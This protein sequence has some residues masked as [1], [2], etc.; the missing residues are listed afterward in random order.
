M[1]SFQ[2][3][4][5]SISSTKDNDEN[6]PKDDNGGFRP[7]TSILSSAAS[8]MEDYNRLLYAVLNDESEGERPNSS[9]SS[10]PTASENPEGQGRRDS[11]RASEPSALEV[12][13]QAERR[14]SKHISNKATELDTVV[15]E[16][17]LEIKALKE[18]LA[19]ATG[20][21]Q[22]P[23]ESP[24]AHF[25]RP[26]R[27]KDAD[28][29]EMRERLAGV[30]NWGRRDNSSPPE[31][32]KR[33]SISM[34][35]RGSVKNENARRQSVTSGKPQRAFLHST[36]PTRQS[37]FSPLLDDSGQIDRQ[38]ELRVGGEGDSGVHRRGPPQR[39]RGHQRWQPGSTQISGQS[40]L[41]PWDAGYRCCAFFLSLSLSVSLSVYVSVSFSVSF[42]VSVSLSLLFFLLFFLFLIFIDSPAFNDPVARLGCPTRPSTWLQR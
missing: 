13:F 22:S 11:R 38:Q 33:G 1:T 31:R 6:V 18:Q 2:D 39:T 14:R 12:L 21:H 10:T 5:H 3:I 8:T 42:S 27:P 24:T 15:S 25:E 32:G 17:Q 37:F 28:V 30:A 26:E 36:S 29:S 40:R 41:L 34:G 19:A 4:F 9:S 23:P 35:R 16:Q 20:A 7:P